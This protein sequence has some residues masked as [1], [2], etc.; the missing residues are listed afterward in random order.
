M[1]N[2]KEMSTWDIMRALIYEGKAEK[3]PAGVH[4]NVESIVHELERRSLKNLGVN[5]E[6]WVSWYLSG[7][8]GGSDEDKYGI[9][10]IYNSYV[11]AK[12]FKATWTG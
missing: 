4:I 7:E 1:C 11:R 10:I 3:N 12:S 9:E 5:I 6:S 8:S 2:L